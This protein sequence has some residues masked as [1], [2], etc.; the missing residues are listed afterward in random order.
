MPDASFLSWP[1]FEDRHRAF[2]EELE[3]WA[4]QHLGHAHGE[5]VAENDAACRQRVRALGD[6]G[7]L[8]A[9]APDPDAAEGD[10]AAR[11]D[12]RTIC[13]AREILARHDGLADFAFAM[14]GL[15]MGAVSLFG[16]AEQR[17]VL[18]R[19]R[20]GDAM[21]A[22]ARSGPRSGS[23]VANLETR[24]TRDGEGWVLRSR[25]APGTPEL[26]KFLND[27]GSIRREQLPDG[28]VWDPIESI[29]LVNLWRRKRLPLD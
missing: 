13:L 10:P 17:A 23:D 8:R 1:F 26:V 19:T 24:A 22:C 20:A 5:S 4:G 21:A 7:W 3:A 15:G 14:Q 12:V 18:R 25:V 2:A 27:D 6:G 9:T 29:E 16:T 28:K 11:L